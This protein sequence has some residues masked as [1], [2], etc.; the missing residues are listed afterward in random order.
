M[1]REGIA[2]T[3]AAARIG[4]RHCKIVNVVRKSVPQ[5]FVF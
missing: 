3:G 4:G 5:Q 1:H 2:C